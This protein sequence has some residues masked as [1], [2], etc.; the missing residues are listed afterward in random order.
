VAF[1]ALAV[2]TVADIAA[3]AA[4]LAMT[5]TDQMAYTTAIDSKVTSSTQGTRLSARAQLREQCG[6]RLVFDAIVHIHRRDGS[7]QP[8][9]EASITMHI[10]AP[11]SI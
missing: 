4:T 5:P 3:G 6:P 8:C 9:G 11:V 1:A 2:G 7:S 10:T